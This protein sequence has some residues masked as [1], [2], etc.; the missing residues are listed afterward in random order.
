MQVSIEFAQK[1][2]DKALEKSIEIGTKSCI[3]VLDS[4]GHL[5]SFTRL[6]N[7]WLGSIDAWVNRVD[8][9]IR[10]AKTACYLAMSSEEIGIL[11]LPCSGVYGNE[12]F[13]IGLITFLGGLP[14]VDNERVFI[15]ATGVS[16][17]TVE[18]DHIVAHAGVN[19]AKFCDVVEYPCRT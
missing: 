2:I 5:K 17:D 9:A 12:H 14:I 16:G 7:A 1:I 4:D 18:N 6:D 19:V 15:G 11:S 3:S 10:K 13:N 8:D